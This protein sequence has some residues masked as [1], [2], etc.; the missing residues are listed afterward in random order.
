MQIEEVPKDFYF[1]NFPMMWNDCRV[2]YYNMVSQ[3]K[4]FKYIVFS[5]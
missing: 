5:K 2:P 3:Q 1:L 4:D